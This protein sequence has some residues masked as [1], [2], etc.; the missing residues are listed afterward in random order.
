MTRPALNS[1][2]EVLAKDEWI[3][4]QAKMMEKGYIGKPKTC[5]PLPESMKHP[6]EKI[7]LGWCE[8]RLEW[9]T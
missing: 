1:A 4:E 5:A 9:H 6:E 7:I 2:Q 8:F 3:D